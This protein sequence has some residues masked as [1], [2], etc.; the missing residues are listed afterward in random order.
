L[1][2]F[3]LQ[4]WEFIIFAPGINLTGIKLKGIKL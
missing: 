4:Q 1:G 2:H 3:E